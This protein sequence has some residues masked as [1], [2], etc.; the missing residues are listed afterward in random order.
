MFEI[1]TRSILSSLR[2]DPLFF[3]RSVQM[4]SIFPTPKAL[5]R[6]LLSQGESR[7]NLIRRRSQRL[8]SLALRRSCLLLLQVLQTCNGGDFVF[9]G[10]PPYAHSLR[11]PSE[12]GNLGNFG[13]YNLSFLRDGDNF[14][15]FRRYDFGG[16]EAPGF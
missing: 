16:Y 8:L 10:K 5:A 1:M 15:D 13:F 11:C 7:K 9:V 14:F 4:V 6:L 2:L 3:S 12:F